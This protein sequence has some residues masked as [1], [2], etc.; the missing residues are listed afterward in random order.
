MKKRIKI[1]CVILLVCL[2]FAETTLIVAYAAYFV[3]GKFKDVFINKQDY[4]AADKLYSISTI[5]SDKERIACGISEQSIFVYN[6]DVTTGDYNSFDVT[7]EVYVWL[8]N[9]LPE[10]KAYTFIY[11]ENGVERSVSITSNEHTTPVISKTLKGGKCSTESFVVTFGYE[12]GEDLTGVP[13]LNVV[14]V[15]TYPVR[16]SGV[17]IGA[18]FVPTKEDTCSVTGGFDESTDVGNFAA[19]TYRVQSFGPTIS[20]GKVVLK[21]NGDVLT[22]MT[23]N[24]SMNFTGVENISDG[25]FTK[26]YSWTAQNKNTDTFAFFRNNQGGYWDGDISWT[27]IEGQVFVEYV[28]GVE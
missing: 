19:F 18:T 10:G 15:P 26:Q 21:W 13:G 4:F 5:D 7:Y 8:E 17:V 6:H 1:I 22:L 16:L 3:K 25:S 14:A 12:D 23:V 28:K 2:F 27:D 24:Q 11:Y 9:V 20:E